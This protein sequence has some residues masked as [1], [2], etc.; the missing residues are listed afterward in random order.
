MR[1]PVLLRAGI[2]GTWRVCL[3]G[4][5]QHSD[6]GPQRFWFRGIRPET[7]SRN[8]RICP[9]VV[10][11]ADSTGDRMRTRQTAIRQT[12]RVLILAFVLAGCAQQPV[13]RS[14][15]PPRLEEGLAV[16]DLVVEASIDGVDPGEG[17]S[18]DVLVLRSAKILWDGKF[19]VDAE[20]RKL[21]LPALPEP[22]TV[23]HNVQNMSRSMVGTT[24]VAAVAYVPGDPTRAWQVEY[25]AN[26]ATMEPHPGAATLSRQL[27]EAYLPVENSAAAKRAAFVELTSQ[28]ARRLRAKNLGEREPTD[29]GRLRRLYDK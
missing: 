27:E 11:A 5:N 24:I 13:A 26:S 23:V 17:E 7:P 12:A 20:G 21:P 8:Y 22:L 2:Q 3:N 9:F 18:P 25:S 16:A 1:G 29:T 19:T 6:E 4:A 15:E 10:T 28:A 14:K